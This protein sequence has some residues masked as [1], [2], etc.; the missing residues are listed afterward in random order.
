MLMKWILRLAG[1]N[2]IK[3][4]DEMFVKLKYRYKIGKKLDLNHVETFCEKIQWLKLYDRNPDYIKMVDKYEVKQY[5]TKIIGEQYVIPT[6][7]IYNSFDEIDFDVLPNQFVLKCTHDS[8]STVI[9][10]DKTKLDF[11]KTKQFYDKKLKE[12]YFFRCREWPYKNVKPKIIVEKYMASE[13]QEQLINYK[14]F[15]FDGEPE[16]LYLT[17]GQ[18]HDILSY[19]DMEFQKTE[20]YYRNYEPLEKF[21]KKP[22]NFEEMKTLAKCLSKGIPFIRVDF[23]EV[24]GKVYFGELTFYPS[25]GYVPFEPEKYNKMIGNMIK[26][27]IGENENEK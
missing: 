4:K 1:A 2:Q 14:F 8:E 27:P 6:L 11:A 20:F 13:N 9:C 3:M 25:S 19:V 10:K 21:P 18:S 17:K 12:K 24:E 22:K 26:L 7:G 23:Y 16:F 5:I 15:C